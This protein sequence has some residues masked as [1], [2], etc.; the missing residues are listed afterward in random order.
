MPF[1]F[2]LHTSNIISIII[3]VVYFVCRFCY[4]NWILANG[5]GW[6]AFGVLFY[7]A[8][9]VGYTFDIKLA[10]SLEL[11]GFDKMISDRWFYKLGFFFITLPIPDALTIARPTGLILNNDSNQD[12]SSKSDSSE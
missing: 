7:L 2:R 3:V 8:L 10:L 5:L 4:E 11:H 12:A 1:L 9:L 6:P